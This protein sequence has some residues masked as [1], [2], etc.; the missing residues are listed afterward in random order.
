MLLHPLNRWRDLKQKSV[1][2][3]CS[4]E[5]T[6]SLESDVKVWGVAVFILSTKAT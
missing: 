1:F 2:I 6:E 4:L 3:H 5:L